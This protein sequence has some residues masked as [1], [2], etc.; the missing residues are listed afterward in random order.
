MITPPLSE[1]TPK[2]L[3]QLTRLGGEPRHLKLEP[4]IGPLP[5]GQEETDLEAQVE[6][7]VGFFRSRNPAQR[8]SHFGENLLKASDPLTAF[9]QVVKVTRVFWKEGSF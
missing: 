6:D 3:I 7:E 9:Q 1:R 4:G 8:V 5:L 2:A